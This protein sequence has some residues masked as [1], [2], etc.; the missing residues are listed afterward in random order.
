M[1]R[2]AKKYNTR[3][4]IFPLVTTDLKEFI[5]YAGHSEPPHDSIGGLYFEGMIWVRKLRPLTIGH[6]F[7]HHVFRSFGNYDGGT[8]LFFDFL[9]AMY[10]AIYGFVRHSDWRKKGN[11]HTIIKY[12]VI[13]WNDW[14]DWQLCRD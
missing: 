9:N 10:E 3:G 11:I 1:V 4:R 12:V 5:K 6:E 13:A 2:K 14:L 8:R 7:T